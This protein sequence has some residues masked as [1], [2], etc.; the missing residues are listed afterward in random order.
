[1]AYAPQKKSLL[2]PVPK[3][4]MPTIAPMSSMVPK[5]QTSIMG[6]FAP[7]QAATPITSSGL[8]GPS[9]PMG[10]VT[11]S[12][13][14]VVPRV[15]APVQ[16][17]AVPPKP[18]VTV[19]KPAAAPTSFTL[20]S[21]A[22]Y[23]ASSGGVTPATPMTPEAPST[24][25][26]TPPVPSIGREEITKAEETYRKNLGLSDEEL[27]TQEE[28]DNIISSRDMGIVGKENMLAPMQSILGEQ[29]NIEKRANTLAEP[30]ERKLARLQAQRLASAEM[31]KFS[32]DRIDKT[33]DRETGQ[34]KD[35]RTEAESARRF[36]VETDLSKQ[37]LAEDKRRA[38][39]EYA[40][41]EKKF[42]EDQRRYGLDYALKARE[43]AVK[44]KEAATSA[45]KAGAEAGTIGN[46]TITPESG[47][48]LQLINEIIPKAG[49]ISGIIRSG[50]FTGT[51][52]KLQ[53]LTSNLS[54]NA[55]KLIKGQGAVSD[56]E[57]KILQDSTNA[58]GSGYLSGKMSQTYIEQ[59]LKKIRGVINANAGLPVVVSVTDPQSGQVKRGELYRNDIYDAASK[60]YI[61]KYE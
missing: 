51:S 56:F 7:K 50:R 25:P 12:T 46:G 14:P 59:E 52:D 34:A 60:G 16:A 31:S 29:A 54:V 38:D 61:I 37:K 10:G 33:I 49:E 17:P 15:Q 19:P 9:T 21:G 8:K 27:K 45:L 42:A 23:N 47:S 4:G 36:G 6:A 13:A 40:V 30:L 43:V 5:P 2:P 32:L 53:Q 11:A 26:M 39:L 35:I 28:L 24:N 58:L 48:A 1:M 22:T 44:E 20:P 57:A 55:R 41:S 18:A 3:I